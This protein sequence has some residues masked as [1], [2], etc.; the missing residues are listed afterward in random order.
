V[1]LI[2]IL[3]IDGPAFRWLE[4]HLGLF[5]AI[6]ADNLVHFSWSAETSVSESHITSPPMFYI[7]AGSIAAYKSLFCV[8]P[9]ITARYLKRYWF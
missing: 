2:A 6:A 5:A 1:F 4:W 7:Y 8:C 3:A 9:I